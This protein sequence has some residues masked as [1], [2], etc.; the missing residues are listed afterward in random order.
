MKHRLTAISSGVYNKSK[1]FIQSLFFSQITGGNKEFTQALRITKFSDIWVVLFWNDKHVMWSLRVDITEGKKV[2]AFFQELCR[3][4][5]SHD[6]AENTIWIFSQFPLLG[7]RGRFRTV[8]LI[9]GTF[10]FSLFVVPSLMNG[11]F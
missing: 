3:N 2:F 9:A 10:S 7:Q 4:F 1:S 8:Y 11:F 6:F 5:S